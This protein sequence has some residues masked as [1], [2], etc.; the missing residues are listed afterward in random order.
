VLHLDLRDAEEVCRVVRS[1]RPDVIFHLAGRTSDA[2]SFAAPEET[3]AVNVLGTLHVLEAARTLEEG[4]RVLVAGSSAVYGRVEEAELPIREE[5]RHRPLSPYGSSK[6]AQ[7]LLA[8]QYFESYGLDVVRAIPFNTTGPGQG[9]EAALPA[10]AQQIVEVER[11]RRPPIMEV[12]DLSARRD[13]LDVRDAVRAL[14]LLAEYGASGEAYNICSGRTW[15]IGELLARLL[16]QGFGPEIAVRRDPTRTRPAS[17]PVQVGDNQ[18]LRDDTGWRPEIAMEQTLR[19]LL[20][21]WRGAESGRR[22]GSRSDY[23]PV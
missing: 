10:F 23:V 21:Y 18:K 5:C 16:E 6:A 20:E 19:D 1:T 9:T 12:G 15:A 8:R 4:C 14:L 17:I 22:E 3:M 7:D 11:G 13:L 2:A